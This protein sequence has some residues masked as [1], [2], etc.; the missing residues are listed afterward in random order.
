MQRSSRRWSAVSDATVAAMSRPGVYPPIPVIRE[1][2][3]ASVGLS[4]VRVP[5]RRTCLRQ[6]AHLADHPSAV[7]LIDRDWTRNECDS[8]RVACH[9]MTYEVVWTDL[10]T[11]VVDAERH[12]RNVSLVFGGSRNILDDDSL[13]GNAF[14][15]NFQAQLFTE[16]C[17]HRRLVCLKRS[18]RGR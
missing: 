1:F 10:Q 9:S 6:Q 11:N 14:P 18:I 7:L 13:F 8:E 5:T 3:L 2:A 15:F 12:T 16:R 17:K 4:V